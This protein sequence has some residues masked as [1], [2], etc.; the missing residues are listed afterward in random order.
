MMVMLM[1]GVSRAG[2]R[3]PDSAAYLTANDADKS[4]HQRQ[5]WFPPPVKTSYQTSS[6]EVLAL[7][8]DQRDQAIAPL[9]PAATT[10]LTALVTLGLVH[11]RRAMK[12]FLIG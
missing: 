3:H 8:A 7:N 4:D 6:P 12:R 9:P 10:G 2:A 5:N 11:C 1:A